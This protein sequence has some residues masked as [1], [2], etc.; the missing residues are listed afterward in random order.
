MT[1]RTLRRPVPADDLSGDPSDD[2]DRRDV[3][4]RGLRVV[5]RGIRDEP[6]IFGVAVV[7]SALYGVGT[8]GSGWVRSSATARSLRGTDRGT[9]PR[10][11]AMTWS[12]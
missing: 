3:V 8:A 12:S 9:A 1:A 11:R 6:W 7:G 5:W 4:R 10:F 2:A